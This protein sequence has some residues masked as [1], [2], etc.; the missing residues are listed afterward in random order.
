MTVG[1]AIM[2]ERHP[3]FRFEVLEWG[4]VLSLYPALAIRVLRRVDIK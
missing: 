4:R 1:M 2:K 3:N